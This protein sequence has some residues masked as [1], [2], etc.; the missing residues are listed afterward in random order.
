MDSKSVANATQVRILPSP[1]LYGGGRE[2]V[3]PNGPKPNKSCLDKNI[4]LIFNKKYVIMN[5]EVKDSYS[6]I[7]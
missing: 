1:P 7:L 3:K 6:N 4:Y 5:I 2:A